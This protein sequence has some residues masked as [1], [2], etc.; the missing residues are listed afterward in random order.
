[1]RASVLITLALN[2]LALVAAVPVTDPSTSLNIEG[3]KTLVTRDVCCIPT[4]PYSIQ[5]CLVVAGQRCC[6]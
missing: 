2:S 3:V 6:F 4:G 5:C 1:M